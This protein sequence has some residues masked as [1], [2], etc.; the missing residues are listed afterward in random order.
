[1]PPKTI[2]L[3]FWEQAAILEYRV[4]ESQS[5]F[6][7][8]AR[9]FCNSPHDMQRLMVA[10]EELHRAERVRHEHAGSARCEAAKVSEER[11]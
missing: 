3:S 8:A 10:A 1:M 9:S 11:G 6:M 4:R 7:N 5:R 2:E